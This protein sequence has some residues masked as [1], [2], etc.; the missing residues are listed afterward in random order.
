MGGANCSP[1]ETYTRS[2]T[3]QVTIPFL[4]IFHPEH[5]IKLGLAVCFVFCLPRSSILRCGCLFGRLSEIEHL[6]GGFFLL[7]LRSSQDDG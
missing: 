3:T 6:C 2:T 7:L 4:H 1:N 5:V